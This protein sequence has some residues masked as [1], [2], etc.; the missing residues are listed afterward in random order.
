M[1][2]RRLV[3]FSVG[4]LSTFGVATVANAQM[5][6]L[7]KHV[8]SSANAAAFINVDKVMASPIAK[9]EKWAANRDSAFASGVSFLPPDA[10]RA[11][12]AMQVD[13]EVWITLWQAAILSLDHE[14]KLDTVVEMTGGTLDKVSGR[15]AVALPEDAYVVNLGALNAAFMAPANRQSVARWLREVDSRKGLGLSPYLTEAYGFAN[16]VGT[17]VILAVDLEDAIPAEAIKDRL[18]NAKPFLAQLK[19]DAN[20]AAK[21]VAN[22]RGA[23]LGVTFTDKIFGKLK[24]DFSEEVKLDPEVAKS[25]LLYVLGNHGAMIDEFEEWKPAVKGKQFTLEGYLTASGMKRLA[26]LFDRPP[27]LKPKAPNPDQQPKTETQLTIEASQ[28]YFKRINELLDDLSKKPKEDSRATLSQI[29]VWMDNY[30]KKIDKLSVLNVDPDLINWG[31]F[32]SDNLRAAYNAIR[33]GAA[34]KRVRQVNEPMQYNYY[35]GG[36][37][38]S[39]TYRS[40]Y[41]Y[42]T[43]AVADQQAY[44]HA[45]TA[46]KTEERVGSANSARDIVQGIQD[47]TADVRKKMT[48]KYKVDF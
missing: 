11:V 27:S 38:Y 42:G 10:S 19:L 34:N 2:V 46:I 14:P 9:K 48:L 28:A 31:A 24:V 23:T 26:S 21:T 35:S 1:H 13:L 33:Q 41:A 3:V 7:A 29:G 8:P 39:G 44:Q 37:A 30:A 5:E 36:V 17:P 45:R 18:D 47:A 43:V 22:L 16:D 40:G 32:V 12:L 25:M 6:G 4:V 15:S 20:T